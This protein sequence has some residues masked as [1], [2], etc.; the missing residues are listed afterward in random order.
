LLVAPFLAT[1]LSARLLFIGGA[2]GV[3]LSRGSPRASDLIFITA[4]CFWVGDFEQ[5]KS[6]A[7][8]GRAF[9]RIWNNF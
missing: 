3:R 2:L 4:S 8:L 9:L 1:G 5:K 6:P 7:F